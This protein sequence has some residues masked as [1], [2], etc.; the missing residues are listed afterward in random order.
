MELLES[1]HL[2]RNLMGIF[3]LTE[4]DLSQGVRT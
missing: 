2:S 4:T 1:N 3:I